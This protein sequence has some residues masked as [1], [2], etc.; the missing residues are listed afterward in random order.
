MRRLEAVD[1]AL[2]FVLVPVYCV[3]F[4]LHVREAA[5]TA[6]RSASRAASSRSGSWSAAAVAGPPRRRAELPGGGHP[7]REKA[8][9]AGLLSG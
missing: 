3:V 6:A 4:G 7:D 5:R 1:W 2:L 8:A 9:G